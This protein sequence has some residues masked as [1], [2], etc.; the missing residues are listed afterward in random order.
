MHI[1]LDLAAIL[2][3]LTVVGIAGV[4]KVLVDIRRH[5][6]TLNGR[7]RTIEEWR[8]NVTKLDDERHQRSDQEHEDIWGAVNKLRDRTSGL[9]G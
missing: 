3:G 7:V 9:G 6:A 4:A 5:L 8:T 1:T 2:S